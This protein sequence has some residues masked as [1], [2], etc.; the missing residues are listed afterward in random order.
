MSHLHIE[1]KRAEWP[2][3]RG[4]TACA[5]FM[6][7][8][9]KTAPVLHDSD[10]RFW[11]C[12]SDFPFRRSSIAGRTMSAPGPAHARIS[13]MPLASPDPGPTSHRAPPAGP[14][15]VWRGSG[16]PGLPSAPAWQGRKPRRARAPDSD[17]ARRGRIRPATTDRQAD[18]VA[19]HGTPDGN[20][21]WR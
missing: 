4:F 14:R 2:K 8:W 17:H 19:A 18:S 11:V 5:S 9:A 20:R 3:V 16:L 7:G 6:L 10:G 12:I 13:R 1:Y 21:G 15:H